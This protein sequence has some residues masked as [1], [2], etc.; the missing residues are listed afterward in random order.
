MEALSVECASEQPHRTLVTLQATSAG[1]SI[2]PLLRT[3]A[4]VYL[5][6]GYV[7]PCS[8]PPPDG[9]RLATTFAERCVLLGRHFATKLNEPALLTESTRIALNSTPE[10]TMDSHTREKKW[11]KQKLN[12]LQSPRY[13][14]SSALVSFSKIT[15]AEVSKAVN[16]R[17]KGKTPGPD[18]QIPNQY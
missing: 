6:V 16:S 8:G 12:K 3:S 9:G 7:Y 5:P 10:Q 4:G 11:R 15:V 18:G 14:K 2:L 17:A 1:W 13:V